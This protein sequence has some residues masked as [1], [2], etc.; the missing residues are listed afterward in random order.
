[1]INEQQKKGE[2]IYTFSAYFTVL[3][4]YIMI[5]TV[6]GRSIGDLTAVSGAFSHSAME[7]IIIPTFCQHRQSTGCYYGRI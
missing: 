1:M 3:A 7:G 4:K 6:T 2:T 5:L